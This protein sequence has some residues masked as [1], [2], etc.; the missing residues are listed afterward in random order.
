MEYVNCLR[1]TQRQKEDELDKWFE[2][3]FKEETV[4]EFEVRMKA[5]T[6][7]NIRNE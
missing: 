4:E 7:R 2:A 3:T 1:A 6:E 5:K